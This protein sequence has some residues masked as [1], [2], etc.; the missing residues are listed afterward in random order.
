M[1]TLEF[2]MVLVGVIGGLLV[3]AWVF[4]AVEDFRA[5]WR[6]K[7][8]QDMLREGRLPPMTRYVQKA[9]ALNKEHWGD[10]PPTAPPMRRRT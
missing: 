3:C 7:R 5:D 9:V 10:D 2:F 6:A 1:M 8:D 4:C